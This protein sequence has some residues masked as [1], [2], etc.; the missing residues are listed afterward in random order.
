MVVLI[1]PATI[2]IP[3]KLPPG[4]TSNNPQHIILRLFFF[5]YLE[6]KIQKYHTFVFDSRY[7]TPIL[8]SEHT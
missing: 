3:P 5:S 2:Y 7:L 6:L 8:L 4:C 1:L